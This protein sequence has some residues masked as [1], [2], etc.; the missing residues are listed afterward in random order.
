MVVVLTSRTMLT[1]EG[2]EAGMLAIGRTRLFPAHPVALMAEAADKTR[3]EL[4][5]TP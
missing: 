3:L 5:A 2:V 1:V 4:L